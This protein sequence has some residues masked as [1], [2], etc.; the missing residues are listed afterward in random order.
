MLDD[1]VVLRP[2]Q[3]VIQAS[4]FVR[5]GTDVKKKNTDLSEQNR[6]DSELLRNSPCSIATKNVG[7]MYFN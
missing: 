4:R 5:L 6:F 7:W 3:N 1:C 2:L